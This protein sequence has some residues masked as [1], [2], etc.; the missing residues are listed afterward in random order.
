MKLIQIPSSDGVML[1]LR[2]HKVRNFKEANDLPE[3][4]EDLF[5]ASWIDAYYPNRPA[6]LTCM[7]F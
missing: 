2:S 6:H 4:S 1:T 5:H 7:T 3:D